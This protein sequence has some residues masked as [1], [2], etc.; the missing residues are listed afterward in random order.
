MTGLNN[1]KWYCLEGT[2]SSNC[3]ITSLVTSG[4]LLDNFPRIFNW[5]KILVAGLFKRWIILKKDNKLYI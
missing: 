4:L 5:N 1:V 3:C 2:N